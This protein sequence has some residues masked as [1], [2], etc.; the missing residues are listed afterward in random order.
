VSRF[1]PSVAEERW[2][3]LAGRMPKLRES[4]AFAVRLGGWRAVGMVTR[5]ALFVLGVIAAAS[6]A[7]VVATGS[8][9]AHRALHL[10]RVPDFQLLT[11]LALIATAEWLI[12]RF[13]LFASGSEEALELAGALILAVDLVGQVNTSRTV[14][15]T[16]LVA[17]ALVVVGLRLFNP[18]F[19]T[20]AAVVV[21]FAI[22]AAID[23]RILEF[24]AMATT[25]AG[26]SC[27]VAGAIALALGT[28][29]LQRPAHDRMLD[30]L[31]L[32]MPLAGYLW[33]AGNHDFAA[34]D[35]LHDSHL[36]GLLA[37]LAPLVYGIAALV[38]GLRRR[39]HASLVAFMLCSACVAFELRA[40]TGWSLQARL[41]I[42]GVALLAAALALEHY[43]RRPRRGLTSQRFGDG[44][45]SLS[46]LQ[47]AG[48][49]I[50]T[51]RSDAPTAAHM[52]PGGGQFAGGGASGN[53]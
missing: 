33:L 1:R 9:L 29:C 49:A 7:S 2:L 13:R 14:F 39:A 30:G 28:I 10:A 53:F 15:A 31:V 8:F 36:P 40:L 27:F 23:T 45:G 26:L 22:E 19:T 34:V 17:A 12:V 3:A 5:C 11:A 48:A 35:Y 52:Q 32:V 25:C 42:W 47:L 16:L 6:A 21:S 46:L 44:A 43:L 41:M 50:L 4:A 18:L 20:L 38:V 51:P 24:S 37:P